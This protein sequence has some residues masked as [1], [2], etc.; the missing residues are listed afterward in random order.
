MQRQW[1]QEE[2]PALA[3]EYACVKKRKGLTEIM[4]SSASA[5]RVSATCTRSAIDFRYVSNDGSSS[6]VDFSCRVEEFD[7]C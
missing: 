7:V 1:P 6:E 4:I 3:N 2:Q 5:L